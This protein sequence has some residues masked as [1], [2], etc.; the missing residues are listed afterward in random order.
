[1]IINNNIIIINM[2]M[3]RSLVGHVYADTSAAPAFNTAC[4]EDFDLKKR[5]AILCQDPRR[6][7]TGMI[8]AAQH[9]SSSGTSL[10]YCAIHGSWRLPASM[11]ALRTS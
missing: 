9:T 11:H 5:D 7:V 3:C 2:M 6:W 10:Q 1:M 4:I 8:Q